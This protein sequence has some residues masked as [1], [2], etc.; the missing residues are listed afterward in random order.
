MTLLKN[1][2]FVTCRCLPFSTRQITVLEQQTGQFDQVQTTHVLLSPVV[3]PW[4]PNETLHTHAFHQNPVIWIIELR[5]ETLK[6]QEVKILCTNFHIFSSF[7]HKIGQKRR[8][9]RHCRII[10]S[11]TTEDLFILHSP[12][13]GAT[14]DAT[15]FAA[16]YNY[17]I[18]ALVERQNTL[19]VH[20]IGLPSISAC[21]IKI[22]QLAVFLEILKFSR[23]ART[24]SETSIQKYTSTITF[25]SPDTTLHCSRNGWSDFE[26]WRSGCLRNRSECL[27]WA[28]TVRLYPSHK[29]FVSYTIKRFCMCR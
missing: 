25:R 27:S 8:S 7:Q 6:C 11:G 21:S 20:S 26:Y 16:R 2:Q 28:S 10:P 15:K 9:F 13:K 1:K 29:L 4:E 19:T 24:V 3:V 17:L 5:R 23:W 18:V 12:D 22:R 14:H